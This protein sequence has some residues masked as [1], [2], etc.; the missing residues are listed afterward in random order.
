MKLIYLY[1][2]FG[3]YRKYRKPFNQ[4]FRQTWL[5]SRGNYKN[6]QTLTLVCLSLKINFWRD[7]DW[8][9]KFS[10]N[11]NTGPF[12]KLAKCRA[13]TVFCKRPRAWFLLV[14]PYDSSVELNLLKIKSNPQYY[15]FCI[16]CYLIYLSL[17]YIL[18]GFLNY[19]H[20]IY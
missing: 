2:F 5:I 3:R 1:I 4:R 17:W 11:A 6:F 19:F 8:H 9:A 16:A 12:L 13:N 10:S 18:F 7:L 14:H 15:S 20:D